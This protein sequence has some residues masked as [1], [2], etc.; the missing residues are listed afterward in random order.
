MD[1][2]FKEVNDIVRNSM[3]DEEHQITRSIEQASV[4]DSRND[5]LLFPK[6]KGLTKAVLEQLSGLR[7]GTLKLFFAN[8]ISAVICA[9]TQDEDKFM[10]QLNTYVKLKVKRYKLAKKTGSC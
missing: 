7:I 8:T 4:L 5:P 1:P 6:L 3:S 2:K 10:E 9:G